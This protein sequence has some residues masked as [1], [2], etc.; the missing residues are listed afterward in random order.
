MILH[1][2]G[3]AAILD[4]VLYNMFY[5]GAILKYIIYENSYKYL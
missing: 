2:T 1:A 5:C 3:A 4:I